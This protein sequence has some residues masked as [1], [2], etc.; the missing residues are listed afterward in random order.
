MSGKIEIFSEAITAASQDV[1]SERRL[2]FKKFL[3][4]SEIIGVSVAAPI[5]IFPL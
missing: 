4:F 5:T 2:P 3:A 1:S